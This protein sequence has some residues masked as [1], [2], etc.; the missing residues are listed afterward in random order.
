MLDTY[1]VIIQDIWISILYATGK[2]V[3][4]QNVKLM[5]IGQSLSAGVY[6]V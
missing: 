4:G 6:P 3:I 2:I 5:S 1:V